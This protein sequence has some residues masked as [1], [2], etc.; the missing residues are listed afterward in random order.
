MQAK[1]K[2]PQYTICEGSVEITQATDLE[3]RV[4]FGSDNE[5]ITALCTFDLLGLNK[6]IT[7]NF[8]TALKEKY[9]GKV[10]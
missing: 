7:I 9:D 10:N 3:Y 5:D 4:A 8:T 2:L 1:L 6:D